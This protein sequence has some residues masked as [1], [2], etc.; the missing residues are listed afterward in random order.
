M[1]RF[2][3]RSFGFFGGASGTGGGSSLTYGSFYDT[4]TQTAVTDTPTPMKLNTTDF[5]NG[6]SIENDL[7]GNPT[8]IKANRSGRYN[9]QFSAQI[10][11]TSG[12]NS[13]QIDIWIR[14]SENNV[15]WSNTQINIQANAGKLVAGWNWFLSLNANQYVQIIWLQNDAIDLLFQPADLTI[16][17]PAVPSVIATIVEV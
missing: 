8:R 5:V 7:L 3:N 12:G 1:S 15:D 6:F 4:T 11:R 14:I 13:R 2:G 9:L 17:H 10:N 16:P